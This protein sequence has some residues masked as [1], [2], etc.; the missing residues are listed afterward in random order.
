MVNYTLTEG[1]RRCLRLLAA[2]RVIANTDQASDA[3]RRY[4]RATE[5]DGRVRGGGVRHAPGMEFL[6]ERLADLPVDPGDRALL[7]D[8]GRHRAAVD[9][10]GPALVHRVESGDVGDDLG[11]VEGQALVLPCLSTTVF[12]PVVLL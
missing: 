12:T 10:V 4:Q 8:L 7:G 1:T 2:L 3:A 11:A 9:R 5:K 6:A